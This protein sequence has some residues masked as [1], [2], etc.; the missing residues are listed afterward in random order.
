MILKTCRC[1]VSIQIW[2]VYCS[3]HRIFLVLTGI[4]KSLV[5]VIVFAVEYAH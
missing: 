5:N 1:G 3:N 2:S 4:T